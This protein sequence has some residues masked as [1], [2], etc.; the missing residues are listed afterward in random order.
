[1]GR[2]ADKRRRII[3]LRG[4]IAPTPLLLAARRLAYCCRDRR[5]FRRA[6]PG[7]AADAD[8]LRAGAAFPVQDSCVRLTSPG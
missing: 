2:S 3:A 7:P 6:P 8:P 4:S 5:R 1:M